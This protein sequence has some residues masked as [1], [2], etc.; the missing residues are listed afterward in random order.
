M[1]RCSGRETWLRKRTSSGKICAFPPAVAMVRT[2][3]AAPIASPNRV[4]SIDKLEV[5]IL[6]RRQG[7]ILPVPL[8]TGGG[9]STARADSGGLVYRAPTCRWPWLATDTRTSPSLLKRGP[10]ASAIRLSGVGFR[11][12]RNQTPAKN[13]NARPA[14]TRPSNPQTSAPQ[15]VASPS[16]PRESPAPRNRSRPATSERQNAGGSYP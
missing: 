9:A 14:T 8:D 1:R 6:P 16:Q 11:D 13:P 5:E 2:T 12:P 4:G 10:H 3:S 15:F 7:M